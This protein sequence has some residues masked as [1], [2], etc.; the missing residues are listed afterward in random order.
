MGFT[1]LVRR[2][3][4]IESGPRAS[5]NMVL[6]YFPQFNNRNIMMLFLC[7]GNYYMN[8]LI[9]LPDIYWWLIQLQIAVWVNCE[10]SIISCVQFVNNLYSYEGRKAN[11]GINVLHENHPLCATFKWGLVPLYNTSH[12]MKLL[13]Q[14]FTCHH[15]PSLKIFHQTLL[16][17]QK[18]L[19]VKD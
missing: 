8:M 10:P 6:T 16:C 4:Y 3:L 11:I 13:W 15:T 2:Y 18:K 9:I 1:I 14:I 12:N 7:H 19:I 5:A 17:V